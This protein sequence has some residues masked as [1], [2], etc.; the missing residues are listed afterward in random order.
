MGERGGGSRG[1]G[2]SGFCLPRKKEGKDPVIGGVDGPGRGEGGRG[3]DWGASVSAPPVSGWGGGIF[4]GE[5][6]QKEPWTLRYFGKLIEK[7]LWPRQSCK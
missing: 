2:G 6:F 3:K 5:V 7:K 1:G 4:Q